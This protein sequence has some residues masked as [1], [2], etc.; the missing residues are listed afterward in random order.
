MDIKAVVEAASKFNDT[1]A[2]CSM[3]IEKEDISVDIYNCACEID[4]AVIALVEKIGQCAKAITISKMYGKSP[5]AK[6]HMI[7]TSNDF[8]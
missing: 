8:V 3:N 7:I 5:L 2:G 6:S 4:E 1:W